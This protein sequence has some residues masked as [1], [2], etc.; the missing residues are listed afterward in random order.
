MV[1]GR[2]GPSAEVAKRREAAMGRGHKVILKGISGKKS[3][4]DPGL[5]EY[6][7]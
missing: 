2:V 1:S 3:R 5:L 6:D 7:P 4:L